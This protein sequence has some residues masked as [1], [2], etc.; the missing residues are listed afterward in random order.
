MNTTATLTETE[1][2]ETAAEALAVYTDAGWGT[3]YRPALNAEFTTQGDGWTF[4]G[5]SDHGLGVTVP[6]FNTPESALEDGI[7]AA[8]GWSTVW[9]DGTTEVA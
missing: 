5:W 2:R 1:A 6:W 9:A 8:A 4:L 7:E 3:D